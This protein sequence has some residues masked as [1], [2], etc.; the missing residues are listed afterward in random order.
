MWLLLVSL[1]RLLYQV[2]DVQLG[3]LQEPVSKQEYIHY[4]GFSKNEVILIRAITT[5]RHNLK[6]IHFVYTRSTKDIASENSLQGSE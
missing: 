3:H 1:N 5:S 6:K 4:E 2:T